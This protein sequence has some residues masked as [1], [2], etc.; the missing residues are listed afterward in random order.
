MLQGVIRIL[1]S[2]NVTLVF[3]KEDFNG[4]RLV[5]YGLKI[6]VKEIKSLEVIQM[7]LHKTSKKISEDT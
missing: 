1:R 6:K 3:R 4:I 5:I 7:L 2:E